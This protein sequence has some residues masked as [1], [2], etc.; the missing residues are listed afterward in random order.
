MNTQEWKEAEER[1]LELSKKPFQQGAQ[2]ELGSLFRKMLTIVNKEPAPGKYFAACGV[3]C[4]LTGAWAFSSSG[5][6][7]GLLPSLI[8][9]ALISIFII[10]YDEW[11]NRKRVQRATESAMVRGD[12]TENILIESVK[13]LRASQA[14]IKKV[15][16]ENAPTAEVEAVKKQI[17]NTE[18]AW[19]K[20]GM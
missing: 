16:S 2:E 3:I 9:L 7:S 15:E 1:I 11:A 4:Y 14:L 13:L 10:L 8:F 19:T 17:T 20:E 5:S 18:T 12:C 6:W